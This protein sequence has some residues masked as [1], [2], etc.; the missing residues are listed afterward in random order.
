MVTPGARREAVAHLCSGHG[1]SQRR[2]CAVLA[3]DRS[4]VRYRSLR[5]EDADLREA[6]RQVAGER[7]RF[8]YRR[9]HLMLERQG[10]PEPV[11]GYIRAPQTQ[12]QR[13]HLLF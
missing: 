7:W 3:I 11:L 13:S 5:P 10:T 1:V 6:M 9:I 12:S 2:E 4:S 8:G